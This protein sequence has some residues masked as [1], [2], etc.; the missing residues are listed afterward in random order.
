MIKEIGT[1]KLK[2][3]KNRDIV[4]V[5]IDKLRDDKKADKLIIMKVPQTNN[6]IKLIVQYKK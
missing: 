4:I 1:F 6:K 5:D 3:K 2:N